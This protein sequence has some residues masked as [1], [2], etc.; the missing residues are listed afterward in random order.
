MVYI[1]SHCFAPIFF[2]LYNQYNTGIEHTILTTN[3]NVYKFCKYVKLKCIYISSYKRNL[4]SI[5]TLVSNKNILNTIISE[6]NIKENDQFFLLDNVYTIEGFYFANKFS[7]KC[8]TY[9][10]NLVSFYPDYYGFKFSYKFFTVLIK[11]IAIEI[12]YNLKLELYNHRGPVIGINNN[13]LKNSNIKTYKLDVSFDELKMNVSD[14]TKIQLGEYENM[15]IDGSYE[16][17]IRKNSIK[18]IYSAILEYCPTIVI[19]PH[20]NFYKT[21]LLDAKNII[22]AYFPIELLSSNIKRNVLSIGVSSTLIFYSKIKRINSISLLELVEW[23]NLDYKTEIKNWLIKESNNKII[24][25]KTLD[26]LFE[27]L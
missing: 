13:F 27:Y 4:R 24:F 22:P 23:V 2:A 7:S 1:N 26:E 12:I 3:E 21:Q 25:V 19:K 11:K 10:L 18:F 5:K 9:Y 15:L 17:I 14:R 6:V 8:Q 20:P 16:G